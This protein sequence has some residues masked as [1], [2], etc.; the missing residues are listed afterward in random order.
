MKLFNQSESNYFES[1]YAEKLIP[2]QDR[3]YAER[4]KINRSPNQAAKLSLHISARQQFEK[5]AS[6]AR[7]QAFIETCQRIGRY[8]SETDYQEFADELQS[9]AQ[10]SDEAISRIYND[11]LSSIRVQT[12][13]EVLKRYN[14]ELGQIVG[15]TLTPLRRFTDEGKL[16]S[17]SEKLYERVKSLYQNT[18]PLD[19]DTAR[20]IIELADDAIKEFGSTN[21]EKKVELR[22]WKAQAEL[23]LP[24]A[25][26]EELRK[27]AEGQLLKK[28]YPQNV[29]LRKTLLWIIVLVIFGG[30]VLALRKTFLG[31]SGQA[32]IEPSPTPSIAMPVSPATTPT[33]SSTPLSQTLRHLGDNTWEYKGIN[34]S[35]VGGRTYANKVLIVLRV[36]SK[37]DSY[38]SVLLGA[39]SPTFSL[40]IDDNGN[41]FIPARVI[42]GGYSEPHRGLAIL[43]ADEPDF[44]EILFCNYSGTTNIQRMVITISNSQNLDAPTVKL[45]FTNIALTFVSTSQFP[46]TCD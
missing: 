19:K 27:R 33:P 20:H 35:L 41:G 28:S 24:P 34:I 26:V 21:Q 22:Q 16:L 40:L 38:I 25:T 8:P 17:G 4:N 37:R 32:K 43:K 7:V 45:E 1:L 15:M 5:E 46:Y 13:E 2:I 39:P 44:I 10:R 36:V 18:N 14:L 12:E 9:L 30:G 29:I 42:I 23:V 11:P 3:Y 31:Q 6:T